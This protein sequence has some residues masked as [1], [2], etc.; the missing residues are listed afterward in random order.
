[1][2]SA[3][4]NKINEFSVNLTHCVQALQTLVR[5][6]QV[7]EV[8]SMT[9][10]KMPG[11]RG[12]MARTD[13]EW[14]NWE[15]SKLSEVIRLWLGGIVKL[16]RESSLNS[17]IG[18]GNAQASRWRGIQFEGMRLLWRCCSQINLMQKINNT[19]ERKRIL[20]RKNLC[21]N[22][23]TPNHRTAECYSKST[24]QHCRNDT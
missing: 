1:M 8:M 19:D 5:L 10:E 20:A 21:F 23:A 9:L 2:T 24:C 11:V 22:C 4:P 16:Q 12:D 7:N 18:D 17:V 13:P 6:E 15:F 14:E 3:N